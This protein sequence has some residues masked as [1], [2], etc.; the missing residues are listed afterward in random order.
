M[1]KTKSLIAPL[2]VAFAAAT[3]TVHA[4]DTQVVTDCDTVETVA[5]NARASWYGPGFHGRKTAN[6]EVFN[7]NALTAAHKTLKLGT[8]VLVQNV[9]NGM[10]VVLRVNDRGPYIE[11]RALDVSQKAA[12]VLGFREDGVAKIKLSICG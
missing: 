12:D 3:G 9:E 5:K 10:Q 7:Q 8:R 2:V 4:R 11:G 6:G 1:P